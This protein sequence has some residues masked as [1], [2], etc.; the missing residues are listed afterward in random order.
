MSAGFVEDQQKKGKTQHF[1]HAAFLYLYP[2]FIQLANLVLIHRRPLYHPC[3]CSGS[4]GLTHQDC[5]QSWLKVQ[6]GDGSCELCKAK[7]RFAPKYAPNAPSKLPAYAVLSG[8]MRRLVAKWLPF[9]I[10]S[11]FAASL[12]M[13]VA[14]LL[15]AYMYHGWMARPSIVLQ[16]AMSWNTIVTDLISG[17]VVASCIIISFLS[18]MSFADFLRLELQLQQRGG[19]VAQNNNRLPNRQRDVAAAADVDVDEMDIDN[20][21]WDEMQIRR[22]HRRVHGK[23]LTVRLHQTRDLHEADSINNTSDIEPSPIHENEHQIHKE[24]DD[25]DGDDE[26]YE[27][28]DESDVDSWDSTVYDEDDEYLDDA[29]DAD[30]N[31]N[32]LDPLYFHPEAIDRNNRGVEEL[33]VPP[34]RRERGNDEVQQ[35]RRPRQGQANDGFALLDQEDPIDMD[36]NI[37][38]DELLGIR[39]PLL[40]VARNLLWLLAFNAIYLGFFAF[41]PRTIGIAMSSIVFNTTGML[42]ASATTAGENSTDSVG[43][44]HLSN[45]ITVVSIWKAIEAESIRHE[46][47]FRLHDIATIALGYFSIAVAV[48]AFRYLWSLSL[49]FR[50]LLRSGNNNRENLADA[51][52]LHGAF[53]EMNRIVQGLG[54]DD[55][56]QGDQADVAIGLALGVAIDVTVAIVKVGVLLFLKMFL[57]PIFL[58]IALDTSTISLFGSTLEDRILYAGK[59]I[60]SFILLHWVAGITFMLL[61]TVS[62]L[63]LRE[64]AHPDLLSQMI[65]PQEPQPD[66]LGNLMNESVSTHS[67]RMVLSLIIYAFL[68]TIHI[69]LPVRFVVSRLLNGDFKEYLE[70]KFS[71]M[72]PPQLQVPLELLFFHLC[73]LAL[74][75]KYK[76]ALGGMQHQWLTFMTKIM[77]LSDCMLPHSIGFFRHVGSRPIFENGRLIDPIWYKIIDNDK[78]T[79][80]NLKLI[81]TAHN[82]DIVSTGESKPS[83]ERV[84]VRVDFI[85]L[86]SPSPVKDTV[87]L[88]TK[89]GRYRLK[90]DEST[91]SIDLWEEVPGEPILRPPEGWDDLGVGGADVQGRWAWGAEKKSKIENSVAVR[92]AF[93]DSNKSFV[94]STI[95]LFKLL[96][97]ACLSWLAASTV[98]FAVSATPL[99][100]GRSLFYIFRVPTK[101]VHDPMAF[102]L[103]FTITFPL[104]KKVSTLIVSNDSPIHARLRAWLGRLRS[105][106]L[107]KAYVLIVT[108]IFWFGVAPLLLGVCYDIA[109]IKSPD[110]F[111]GNQPFHSL[112]ATYWSWMEG[113]VL[114]YVWADLCILGVLTRNYRVFAV[115]GQAQ[116]NNADEVVA[117]SEEA[118]TADKNLSWQGKNGRVARF[119]GV[120]KA[121]VQG[122]EWDQVDE[123]TLLQEFSSPIVIELSYVL[124]IPILLYGVCLFQFPFLSGFARSVIVRSGLALTCFI[125]S[126]LPWKDQLRNFFYLAHK[127][128]RDDLYL[129]G[130]ILMNYGE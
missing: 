121:I 88:P 41:V 3:V 69:L 9:T 18:L 37:A 105:P 31:I 97:L 43:M 19:G 46:T 82:T 95:V 106:P 71:Y 125:R 34:R 23:A 117:E 75:E 56:P 64:V 51:Y 84:V 52:N 101:W 21:I 42:N 98:L 20:G 89:I 109:F 58:G 11:A 107:H 1:V 32:D 27:E 78:A 110:W 6:R 118:S 90:R 100:V 38:L 74:L 5:L 68:L 28:N 22:S 96:A 93:F 123:V 103:G 129:I 119:W 126:S 80:A 94:Q 72:L 111:D 79:L 12:W 30:A 130:E 99:L 25:E 87:L 15:T 124:L 63:Q 70:L 40:V 61:V 120:W 44:L 49:K 85:R 104:L 4:I 55:P 102:G 73:M 92:R 8:M 39:G 81:F 2:L 62:V 127:T 57:L 83:G 24:D 48:I 59:D 53:D 65:R 36:I 45:N 108:L 91:K 114:L 60:F 115:D 116:Q 33:P 112:P 13:I 50:S 77:G 122:W 10:R 17:G 54:N 29:D 7:F 113:T 86:P 14:P 47:A 128:A 16:R 26:D 76:N 35:R 66:L 67:K